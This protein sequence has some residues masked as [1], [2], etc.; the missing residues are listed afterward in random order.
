MPNDISSMS[1]N[2]CFLAFVIPVTKSSHLG[3]L[4]FR[5]YRLW[6]S[7]RVDLMVFIEGSFAFAKMKR[8]ST[9]AKEL[10]LMLSHLW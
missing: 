4:G 7:L 3:R 10:S 2:A 6:N 5:P 8:L 1:D 9:K